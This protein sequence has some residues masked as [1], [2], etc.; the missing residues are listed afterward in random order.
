MGDQTFL[1]SL[2]KCTAE[3]FLWKRLRPDEIDQRLDR[4]PPIFHLPSTGYAPSEKRP[5]ELFEDPRG[6]LVARLT[7]VCRHVGQY[8]GESSHTQRTVL[9]HGDM[10]FAVDRSSQPHVAAGLSRQLIST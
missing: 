5:R 6:Q 9:R 8:S 4:P 10:V 2:G 3:C 7:K 1:R